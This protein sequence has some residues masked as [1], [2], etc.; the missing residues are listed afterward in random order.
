MSVAS[1]VQLPSKEDCTHIAMEATQINFT[2]P[3]LKKVEMPNGVTM[4]T[5]ESF[6]IFCSPTANGIDGPTKDPKVMTSSCYV[7]RCEEHTVIYGVLFLHTHTV[8]HLCAHT[9][10]H[11]AYTHPYT[12]TN[13]LFFTHTHS[14]TNS[15]T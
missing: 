3:T 8:T 1:A 10:A 5:S 12:H 4:D 7:V 13:Y 11:H 9:S 6:S 14:Y 2:T 15:H